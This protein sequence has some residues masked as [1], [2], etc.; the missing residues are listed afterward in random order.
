MDRREETQHDANQYQKELAQ[1]SGLE[2]EELEKQYILIDGTKFRIPYRII[3][4]VTF[5]AVKQEE[6]RDMDHAARIQYRLMLNDAILKATVNFVK[7]TINVVYNQKESDNLKE[8][9][10]KEEIIQMLEKE[11]VHID[12]NQVSERDYDYVKEFYTYA[13]NPARIR[14]HPPYGYTMAQWRQMKPA[15]EAKQGEYDQKKKEDFKKWQEQYE[16]EY[17][18]GIKPEVVAKKTFIDKI[19]GRKPKT[20]DSKDK[21]KGFW[22]HGV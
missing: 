12:P 15:W 19:L 9:I 11:G 1:Q 14:E 18:Q 6:M 8:K 5:S 13:F 22:F 7:C 4:K 21:G 16:R 3:K 10:S 2:D 17:I 20:Q